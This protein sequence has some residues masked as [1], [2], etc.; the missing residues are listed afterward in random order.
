MGLDFK[1]FGPAHLLIL[2]AV[3][4]IGAA[5]AQV[6]RRSGRAARWIRYGLGILMAINELTWYAYRL[7]YEG[8]RFPEALPLNLCDLTLWLTV[9][10]VFTLKSWTFEMAYFA[11]LG[12]SGMALL[13]PDLWAAFFSYPTLYFFL[14][15]GTV[16]AALLMLVWSK[17]AAP[18]P[19]S[20]WRV[21]GALNAY[22][23]AMGI[24]NLIFKTNYM[25]L[26]QKPAGAS[27]L[28]L[29]GPWPVYLA[30]C[31]AVAFLIFWLLWLPF[32]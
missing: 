22:A 29:L 5:L 19:G 23:A 16:V 8:F 32:R 20:W 9:A 17:L 6:C 28:D 11:G 27:L 12:G 1:L 14:A 10:T 31:E 7:H 13:T 21:F 3:P 25:Y 2:A 30:G 15:H 18:R 4:G 26:C 24:F